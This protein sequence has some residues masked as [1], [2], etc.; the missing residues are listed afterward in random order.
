MPR[1]VT[2]QVSS[3][4]L[5]VVFATVHGVYVIYFKIRKKGDKINCIKK[6]IAR[7]AVLNDLTFAG[8]TKQYSNLLPFL[9]SK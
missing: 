8:F 1:R 4:V 6:F 7:A 2:K 9:L 5:A 3:D